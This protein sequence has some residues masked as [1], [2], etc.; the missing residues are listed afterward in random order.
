MKESAT[1]PA[2]QTQPIKT[3]SE[4]EYIYEIEYNSKIYADIVK[5]H[6]NLSTSEFIPKSHL[7]RPKIQHENHNKIHSKK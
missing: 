5:V 7:T 6:T 1:Y 3:V 4:A 2:R